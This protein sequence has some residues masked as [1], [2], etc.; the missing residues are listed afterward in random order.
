MTRQNDI[1]RSRID[2]NIKI[3]AQK[4]LN[5]MGLSLSDAVR[6]FFY[7]IV[8]EQKIPF[9]IKAPNLETVKALQSHKEN[10]LETTSLD[11]IHASWKNG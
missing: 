8:S 2:H 9:L 5:T 6:L 1:I 4:I 3:Q 10:K 7:Q 11:H